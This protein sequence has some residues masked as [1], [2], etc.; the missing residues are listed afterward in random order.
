MKISPCAKAKIKYLDVMADKYITEKAL[1]PDAK[2][3]GFIMNAVLPHCLGPKVLELG[4]G[5]GHWTKRLVTLG[6]DVT[7][8]EGSAVLAKRCK[9][10][11]GERVKIVHS[12]F[13]KFKPKECYGSIIASCVLEHVE[14]PQNLLLLL[15]SWLG[16]NGSLHIVVP[17]A[18]SLHRRIGLKMKMLSNELELSPQELE[19]GHMHAYTRDIFKKQLEEA[20]LK[21]NFIK[22]IFVKPLSSGQMIDWPDSLLEAYN[23]LSE[24][25]PDYTAFLY[26]NCS[27]ESTK[28][29]AK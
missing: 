27:K 18:L 10:F 5:S 14:N 15:K 26:G 2:Q 23:K 11:F 20:R 12:L 6:F 22:G 24:E 1:G 3:M 28:R 17:N 13:E 21:V 7:V 9:N 25:L 4:Y 8:I 29:C 16:N 19:V